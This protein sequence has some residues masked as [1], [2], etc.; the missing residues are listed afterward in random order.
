MPGQEEEEDDAVVALSKGA[1]ATCLLYYVRLQR[2]RR[3]RERDRRQRVQ[4]YC[5]LKA[6]QRRQFAALWN[7]KALS[8]SDIGAGSCRLWSK[9]RCSSSWDTVTGRAFSNLDWMENFR[10]GK[11]TFYYL[12][13]RLRLPDQRQGTIMR[14]A[15]AVEVRLAMTFWRLGSCCEYRTIERLFGVSRSTICKVIREVC[16]AVV[17][18][19]TPTYVR[20]PDGPALQDALSQFEERYGLPQ[21][22]GVVSALHVPIR[23]PNETTNSY[24]NAKGWYSVILQAV[25]DHQFC[26]WDLNVGCPGKISHARVLAN[27]E[28]YDRASRGVLFPAA[29]KNIAGVDVPIYLLGDSAYPLLPWLMTPFLGVPGVLTS[30]QHSFNE[31]LATARLLAEV[32]FTRLKGRW[33]CLMKHNDM[34]VAFLP[35]LIAAC[36]TLHNICELH[37]DQ[38]NPEWAQRGG[39]SPEE[40]DFD[41]PI[42]EAEEGHPVDSEDKVAAMEIRNVISLT[43]QN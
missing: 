26:F 36:C 27:S 17:S 9:A 33:R 13:S 38:F 8:M 40:E 43:L 14:R 12:C 7:S 39:S 18:I 34:D 19:L 41:Q 2:E 11:A 15:I 25:V 35:T 1:V 21:V 16:E 37:G 6:K 22:A 32:A 29:S 30:E 23:A 4:L 24:F 5:R 31:R 3:R 42:S 10:M 20:A 28:L